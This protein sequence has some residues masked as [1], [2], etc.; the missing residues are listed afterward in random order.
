MFN[1]SDAQLLNGYAVELVNLPFAYRAAMNTV[2]A[3]NG[4]ADKAK[5]EQLNKANQNKPPTF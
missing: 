4:A 3:K 1:R 2:N 5:Q